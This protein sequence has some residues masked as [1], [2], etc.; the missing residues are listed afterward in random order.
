MDDDQ[1]NMW[2]RLGV[3][4]EGYY[5]IKVELEMY[6]GRIKCDI[7]DQQKYIK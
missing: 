4:W 5:G 3:I 6:Q 2:P 1:R 7:G